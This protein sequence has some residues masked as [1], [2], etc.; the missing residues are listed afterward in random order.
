MPNIT[1]PDGAVRQFDG[2]VTGL[3][4]AE[5]IGKGLAR[6]AVAMR[7]N[8]ELR[9]LATVIEADA[10]AAIVT[11]SEPDGLD[12]PAPR[13]GARPCR[14][15]QGASSRDAGH[16]RAHHRER[17]LL[18]LRPRRAVHPR[19]TSSESRNECGRSWP[20]TSPFGAR[21][22]IAPRRRSSSAASARRT[23]RR[24]SRASPRAT[25]SRCI[26]REGSSICAAGRTF[27]PPDGSAR[28]FK[29]TSVAGAYWR[30]DPRNPMLQRIYGTAWADAKA[31]RA[32]LRRIE[33]AERRDHRRLGRQMNLFHFQEESPGG[34]VLAPRRLDPVPGPH[35]LH[36]L[37]AGPRPATW[38]STPRTSWTDRCGRRRGTGRRSPSTCTPP[39]PG[40]I[41]CSP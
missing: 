6:D 12:P 38:R 18:R 37:P 15:G 26:A 39:R 33:E 23:R 11:R 36:A 20:A 7:L 27:P 14:G 4:L 31:L 28:A 24:S 16:Y 32:H 1:L 5:S 13:R 25:R 9:D 8:G 2:P 34:G 19:T 17:L 40:T 30:G 10:A 3:E 41:G 35:R 29:L 21:R 22:G